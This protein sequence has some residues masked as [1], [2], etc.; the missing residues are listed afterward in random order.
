M[1]ALLGNGS[2]GVLYE[3]LDREQG[4]VVAL[5]VLTQRSA[6]SIAFFKNEFRALQG[7]R[8]PNLV[9]LRELL[10]EEGHW[11]LSMQLV[12]GID[13]VAFARGAEARAVAE[14]ISGGASAADETVRRARPTLEAL[15]ELRRG[16]RFCE[17]RVRG[18]FRQLA[19]GVSALH[20]ASM[21]HR[22]LKPSNVQVDAQGRVVVLDFG[23]VAALGQSG[24]FRAEFLLG[25]PRYMAPEQAALEQLGP[26][27][28]WY[29]V[30]VMLYEALTG[31]SPFAA[32][33]PL[34]EV[35]ASGARAVPPSERVPA[36]PRDLSELC[37][38]L[39]SFDPAQR[40]NGA[41]IASR[42]AAGSSSAAQSSSRRSPATDGIFVGREGEFQRLWAAFARVRAG[43]PLRVVVEGES[44][45]GKTALVGQFLEQARQA[46]PNLLCFVGRS[47]ERESLPYKALD[48]VMDAVC[49]HL[50]SLASA[51]LFAVLPSNASVI[52]QAFPALRQL[53]AFVVS[54]RRL[55]TTEPHVLRLSIFEALRELFANLCATRPT[56]IVMDDLQWTDIDSLT[57]LSALL[58]PPGAPQMLLIA[59]RR[60]G[61]TAAAHP[62]PGA[63]QHLSLG[64][65]SAAEA[66]QLVTELLASGAGVLTSQDEVAALASGAQGHPLFLR[67]LVRQLGSEGARGTVGRL[68]D[69]L[70]RRIAQLD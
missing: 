19:E 52:A 37:M 42:L 66:T 68:E 22:D 64:P 33:R 62:L 11:L 59:M 28:D 32:R 23:L 58:R 56:I 21:I 54:E 13:I 17:A 1:R 67:E 7:I 26:A 16:G 61:A 24:T 31:V 44:G 27:S 48:G 29:S 41:E 57:L 5:K 70:W 53:E 39:L 63:A 12:R 40:P 38:Q 9:E 46:E 36:V 65:L 49:E 55:E 35:E 34:E 8:H 45:V 43:E 30:G 50:K 18:G 10:C 60:P 6:E 3:A 2:S 14:P 15:P 69:A 4:V 47:F 51:E 20:A 25:T